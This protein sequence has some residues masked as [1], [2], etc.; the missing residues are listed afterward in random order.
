MK[1][2]A[3]RTPRETEH[4]LL[5]HFAG[6]PQLL[7]PCGHPQLPMAGAVS[8]G[9]SGRIL[10]TITP[11]PPRACSGRLPLLTVVTLCFSPQFSRLA[12]AS[13]LGPLDGPGP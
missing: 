5:A 1:Y 12:G 4:P 9:N 8:W 7:G 2:H 3:Q 11:A 6:H 10:P 13:L